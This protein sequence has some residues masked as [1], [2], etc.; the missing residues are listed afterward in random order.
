MHVRDSL[1]NANQNRRERHS[2]VKFTFEFDRQTDRQT[3]RQ[4]WIESPCSC[5]STIAE[6]SDLTTA[7]PIPDGA[8]MT[9]TAEEQVQR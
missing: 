9:H 1:L 6:E 4:K 8:P 7:W 2:F 5:S 3:D